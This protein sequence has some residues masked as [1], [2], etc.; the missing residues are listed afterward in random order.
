V[1]RDTGIN[2]SCFSLYLTTGITHLWSVWNPDH[3]DLILLTVVR[4]IR[5]GFCCGSHGHDPEKAARCSEAPDEYTL[6][7]YRGWIIIILLYLTL[8]RKNQCTENK[9]KSGKDRVEITTVVCY[10]SLNV[11]ALKTSFALIPRLGYQGNFCCLRAAN[12]C[13]GGP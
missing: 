11:I 4:V 10:V 3:L 5:K 8:Q 12:E 7:Q 6:V 1:D 13:S 9:Q 2:A